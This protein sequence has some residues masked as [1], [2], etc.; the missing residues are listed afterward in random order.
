MEPELLSRE[1]AAEILIALLEKPMGVRE[2]HRA[3]GGVSSLS[4]IEQRI[5]DLKE[6]GLIV[7]GRSKTWPQKK[8]L[9]L[10][11]HGLRVAMTLKAQFSLSAV[12]RRLNKRELQERGKWILSLLHVMGGKIEGS[13]RLQKLLF[14]LQK[15]GGVQIPY[16]YRP[17]LHGPYSPDVWG[18]I[19]DMES[20][21]WLRTIREASPEPQLVYLT[22]EGKKVAKRVFESLPREIQ[23]A[24]RGLKPFGEVP[25]PKLL[26]YVY[27]KYPEESK[28]IS[29]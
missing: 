20:V 24:V 14:L 22:E 9:Q 10:T 16:Q 4:T 1:K 3:V 18:D 15:E 17:F 29:S 21:G 5:E 25:L 26:N 6:A 13:V 7:E 11:E 27:R 12:G 19:Y 8:Q 2:L 28:V 23:R